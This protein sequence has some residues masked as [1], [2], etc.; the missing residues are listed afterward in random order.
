ME[1]QTVPVKAVHRSRQ[2]VSK[3]LVAVIIPV[4]LLG[5]VEIGLRA[6]KIGN[7]TSATRPCTVGGHP[8]SCDNP[9]F[10]S[11]FFPHGMERT[12]R[13][14]AILPGKPN[15]TVRIVILGESAAYGD[16]DPTYAF[17]RYLEVMLRETFPGT[18]F[19]VINTAITAINSHVVLPIA[20]DM[21]QHQ[22]DIFIVYMGNN[23]VV[24]PFGPGTV[25]TRGGSSLP[26]IRAGISLRSSRIGQLIAK[27]FD[28]KQQNS[29]QWRGM[30][31]FLERQVPAS[32]PAM[33][34]VYHNFAANLGDIISVARGSGAQVFVSTVGTNVKDCAPFASRHREGMD[35]ESLRSWTALVQQ[36]SALE[37]AGN[38]PEAL[39][40]YRSAETIDPQYAELQFRIARCLW[41]L[42]D[43][44]TAKDHFFLARDLDTLRFRADRRI[45]DEIR[46]VAKAAGPGVELVDAAA[47]FDQESAHGVPGR[48]LFYEHVH[49]TPQ[50]NYLLARALFPQVASKLAPEIRQTARNVGMLSEVDCERLL[51]LTRFDRIRLANEMLGRLKRPP[52]SNQL[53]HSEQ[54]EKMSSEAQVPAESGE[55]TVAQY[56]W[57]ISMAP[58]DRLLHLNFGLFLSPFDQ[59]GATQQFQSALPYDNAPYLCNW[60]RK[61]N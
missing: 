49:M 25:L 40:L 2:L 6:F 55:E 31:M 14:Y 37:D 35:Q 41:A 5:L 12:P 21:A 11:T 27:G 33:E 47:M 24:G 23:E 15:T 8:A 38:L 54:L 58:D 18:K 44:S 29:Q 43:Y 10:S 16:P 26:I 17:S 32:S 52:F 60:P 7:P 46:S 48:E 1:N 50:G 56:E 19:E 20:K 53:N 9:F 30:G 51:A 57:A 42:G 22:P 45:N 59:A 61:L 3:I 28:P 39:K 4:L 34:R 36:G 13:P